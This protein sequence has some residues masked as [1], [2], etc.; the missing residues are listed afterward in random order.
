[1]PDEQHE[2]RKTALAKDTMLRNPESRFFGEFGQPFCRELDHNSLDP[3]KSIQ[4]LG[5]RM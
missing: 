5:E 2:Q 1:M 3:N 4:G